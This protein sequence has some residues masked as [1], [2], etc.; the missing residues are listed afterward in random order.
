[1][2]IF[3]GFF[4]WIKLYRH[5]RGGTWDYLSCPDGGW[6]KRDKPVKDFPRTEVY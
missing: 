2:F 4:G 1:M 6:C 3:D 5:L